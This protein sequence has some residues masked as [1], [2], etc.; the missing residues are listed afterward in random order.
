[1][2]PARRRRTRAALSPLQ[3]LG[4]A[5]VAALVLTVTFGS[6][7]ALA[8]EAP[9]APAR[10]GGIVVDGVRT[11][12]TGADR[13][14]AMHR[15]GRP[16]KT[17]E[18]D[19]YRRHDCATG[20]LAVIVEARPGVALVDGDDFVKAD[21]VKRVGSPDIGDHT[22]SAD[23][24]GWEASFALAQG[25][26]L[27]NVHAQVLDGGSQTSAV[28]DRAIALIIEC[29]GVEPSVRPSAQPAVEPS[30]QPESSVAPA[31]E[32]GTAPSV[33]PTVEPSTTP[34]A[35]VETPAAP[36]PTPTPIAEPTGDPD[37]H[38]ELNGPSGTCACDAPGPSSQVVDEV[39][40]TV[41]TPTVAS[42]L[43]P[44][45]T[46]RQTVV[47]TASATDVGRLV[48]LGLA[49]LIATALMVAR[50]GRDRG[51]VRAR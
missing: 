20:V 28:E 35:V 19:L 10:G 16:D 30:Q 4:W 15:A 42:P 3:A 22:K 5:A 45:P 1:M 44:P 47:P 46:D 36:E 41:G 6:V 26:H 37:P 32:P 38:D 33:E 40:G 29:P 14:A 9:S 25:S 48:L 7:G 34:G 18:S 13:F 43:T 24:L 31:V 11:D 51:E 21:G 27:L 39:L 12:R 23:H 17:N 2:D 49:V 50:S 8:S